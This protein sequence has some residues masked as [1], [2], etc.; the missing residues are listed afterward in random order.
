[1]QT[2]L[3]KKKI[4]VFHAS[5]HQISL[6]DEQKQVGNQPTHLQRI[7]MKQNKI[8]TIDC[9]LLVLPLGFNFFIL[10]LKINN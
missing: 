4:Y 10:F 7:L 5:R 9:W 6:S 2:N 3:P 8:A 1:V